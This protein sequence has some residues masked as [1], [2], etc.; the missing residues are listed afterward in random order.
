MKVSDLMIGDWIG[1]GYKKA[2]VTSITCDGIVETTSGISNIEVVDPIPLTEEILV[3][4]DFDRQ[5]YDDGNSYW[6]ASSIPWWERPSCSA[7]TT[8][9]ISATGYP[10]RRT[11]SS[12]A[13]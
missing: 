6:W 3:K 11:I 8:C 12:R 9:C 13:S 4:N 1:D 7:A 5:Y 2:Q 10:R